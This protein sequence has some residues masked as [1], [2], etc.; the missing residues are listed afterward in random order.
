MAM[1]RVDEASHLRFKRYIATL[2]I[3]LDEVLTMAETL[4]KLL[5]LGDA[6]IQKEKGLRTTGFDVMT[7]PHVRDRIEAEK[8]QRAEQHLK[9]IDK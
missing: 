4:N 6:D 7:P 5:D 3:N 1:I 8:Q 9:N 2:L